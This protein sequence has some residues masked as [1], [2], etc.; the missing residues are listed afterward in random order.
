MKTKKQNPDQARSSAPMPL[1]R[2]VALIEALV[3]LL[4]MAFGMVALAG[5][6]STMRRGSDQ[7]LQRGE[8]LR[9]AQGEMETLRDYSVLSAEAAA[10][11]PAGTRAYAGVT[12]AATNTAG[13]NTSFNIT[14]TVTDW[15]D[16]VAGQE[17]AQAALRQVRVRVQW[18]DRAD[19]EQFVLLDSFIARADPALGASLGLPLSA[20]ATRRPAERE[21]SI[22]VTAQDLGN[23]K[24]VFVPS[25]NATV[26]WVFNNM[27]G[28]I[29]GVC[30]V[31]VGTLNS[32]L[33]A[34][35]VA[36]CSNTTVGYLLS[37]V[38]KFSSAA[39]PDPAQ[40]GGTAWPLDV[41]IVNST[42]NGAIS[43]P[44]H[45]CF[46]DAPTSAVNTMG[47]VS[48]NCIVEPNNATPR[49]WSGRLELSGLNLGVGADAKKVCRYSADYDGS[50]SI[51]NSEHP[52]NY[53][54][55][56]GSLT[57]QNFLVINAAANCPAGAAVNPANGVFVNNSTIQQ[58]PR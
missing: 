30:T 13:G 24:S 8:A 4:I 52:E 58:Q 51:S 19:N 18:Q 49:I 29:T 10:S 53:N 5:I 56:S 20:S 46:D 42:L 28:V 27:T 45:Q 50:G 40:P 55:V 2:G 16:P 36:A 15:A 14:R 21:V 34:A 41:G 6:Q 44:V 26:A 23:G 39:R 12:S 43:A 17:Q 35:D 32:S 33:T 7:A 48:F 25:P 3:A 11:G 1:E 31:A 37:G 22:P 54:A 9:L 38:V 47:F 57:R